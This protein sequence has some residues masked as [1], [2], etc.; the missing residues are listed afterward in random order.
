MVIR[1]ILDYLKEKAD[2]KAFFNCPGA[3]R[4]LAGC[5]R[6]CSTDT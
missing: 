1:K 5:K 2:A 4:R 3:V 6:Y